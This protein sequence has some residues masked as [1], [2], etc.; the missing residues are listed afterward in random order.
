MRPAILQV[1]GASIDMVSV[2]R[3]LD[4]DS[5]KVVDG[6]TNDLVNQ[7][8]ASILILSRTFPITLVALDGSNVVLSRGGQAL[9]SGVR[10]AMVTMGAEIKNPQ[11]GRSLG[12]VEAPCRELVIDRVTPNL[13]YGH[14]GN[15]RGSMDQMLP[16]ALQVREALKAGAQSQVVAAR[17]CPA[18]VA[19]KSAVPERPRHRVSTRAP[20]LGGRDS[21][22]GITQLATFLLHGPSFW[23]CPADRSASAG[24]QSDMETDV[25]TR[26]YVAHKAGREK[27]LTGRAFQQTLVARAGFEPATFGL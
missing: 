21:H 12:R 8:V 14:I 26:Q 15:A 24:S 1:T 16:G 2:N 10:Y 9:R 22:H 7:V 3:K 4:I 19:E 18:V 5:R 6:M 23:G 11:T 20:C 27:A 25:G 13:S 17:T